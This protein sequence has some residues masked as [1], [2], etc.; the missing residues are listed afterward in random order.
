ML[1]LLLAIAEDADD[2][3]SVLKT[4][5]HNNIPGTSLNTTTITTTFSALHGFH[6]CFFLPFPSFCMKDA[7]NPLTHNSPKQT[8]TNAKEER[9]REAMA[10]AMAS[11]FFLS[12]S[13]STITTISTR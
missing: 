11:V 4:V 13:L 3:T 7:M 2:C 1:P 6:S 10:M 5:P 12:H 8:Q 9:K